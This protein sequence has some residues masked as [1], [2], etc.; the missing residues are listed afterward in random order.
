[1]MKDQIKDKQ[2]WDENLPK[3]KEYIQKFYRKS[4]KE[5]KK[6]TGESEIRPTQNK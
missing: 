3:N 5:I 6:M 4:E 1:M 2:R